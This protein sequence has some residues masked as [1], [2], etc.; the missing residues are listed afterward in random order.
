MRHTIDIDEWPLDRERHIWIRVRLVLYEGRWRIDVRIWSI[1]DDG[2]ERPGK[3]L[4]LGVRHLERLKNA[5]TKAYV[6]A[7]ARDLIER[8]AIPEP[9]SVD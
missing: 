9:E 1:G 6:G 8:P 7:V 2:T 5:V 3:A 4:A